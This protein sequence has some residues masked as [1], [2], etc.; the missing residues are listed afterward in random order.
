MWP[1]SGSRRL[2][3]LVN[4][5]IFFLLTGV[6]VYAQTFTVVHSFTGGSDGANPYSGLVMDQGGNLYGTA[7]AGS[8][9]Y[10]NV[11]RLVSKNSAWIVQALYGFQG[12]AHNHDGARPMA[13]IT[14]RNGIVYGT[15]QAGGM[16][17]CANNAGCGTIFKLRPPLSVCQTVFC[18]WTQ[19]VLYRFNGNTDGGNP[20]G[21]LT[22]DQGG[23]L[24]GATSGGG[25]AGS[26]YQPNDGCG[27]VYLLNSAGSQSVLYQMPAGSGGTYPEAGVSF[28]TSGNLLGTTSAGGTS[29]LGTIF[30]LTHSGGNW[31]PSSV[32]QFQSGAGGQL[33]WAG[34]V[35]DSSGNFFGATTAGGADGGGTVYTAFTIRRRLDIFLDLQLRCRRW[36][37]LAPH[38]RLL[39]QSLR[40]DSGRWRIWTWN[41]FQADAFR[42]RLDLR[43]TPRFHWWKRRRAAQ[44]KCRSGRQWQ[45]LRHSVR[46]RQQQLLGWV[47]RC[48]VSVAGAC[49]HDH[50]LAGWRG[51]PSIRLNWQRAAG[52]LRYTW[53]LTSGSLP[54]GLNLSTERSD[55]RNSIGTGCVHVYGSG[56]GPTFE[57]RRGRTSRSQFPRPI[58]Q[59]P[60]RN[61]RAEH[62]VPSI[63]PRYQPAAAHHRT[64]GASFPARFLQDSVWFP[65]RE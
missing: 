5:S 47:W 51:R 16:S 52:S 42:Q 22:F 45:C 4:L 7:S 17:G 11:Y 25:S 21:D 50:F 49:D 18:A 38:N 33:P 8:L 6:S 28:D 26:R 64:V 35:G 14:L 23:N 54:T 31:T 30:R 44:R 29:N 40:H 58:S 62:K 15:T 48:M 65:V 19:T 24:Y 2:F 3:Y 27:V 41:S 59:S 43:L 20:V 10:G 46:R 37:G 55:Q 12:A 57:S 9:G 1:I 39:R 13:R 34:L 32:Y 61:F 36:P 63:T 60:R 56:Q 53:S